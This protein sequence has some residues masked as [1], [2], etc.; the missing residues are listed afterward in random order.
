MQT[1]LVYTSSKVAWSAGGGRNALK[2]FAVI[3]HSDVLSVHSTLHRL[4]ARGP[5]RVRPELAMHMHAMYP[6]CDAY[7]AIAPE[8][9]E[10]FLRCTYI[11]T[12]THFTQT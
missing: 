8:V 4:C 11:V 7:S 2:T 5:P 10:A 9:A 3:F 12:A 1:Y 6:Y